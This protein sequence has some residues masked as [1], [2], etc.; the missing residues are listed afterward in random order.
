MSKGLVFHPV[1]HSH[2]CTLHLFGWCN[3]AYSMNALACFSLDATSCL[4]DFNN[5][6]PYSFLIFKISITRKKMCPMK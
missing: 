3:A 6:V 2:M 5:T 1:G 4:F